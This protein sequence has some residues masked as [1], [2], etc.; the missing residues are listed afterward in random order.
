[1][2]SSFIRTNHKLPR[3]PGGVIMYV[4][5]IICTGEL[6]GEKHRTSNQNAFALHS[7]PLTPLLG[8]DMNAYDAYDAV[9]N[10][11]ICTSLQIF[12]W[13]FGQ[14]ALWVERYCTNQMP[15]SILIK[16][17]DYH[18]VEKPIL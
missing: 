14:D 18:R 10:I 12:R 9:G 17:R 2:V 16:K 3:L 8:R 15:I 1:M 6:G 4:Q 13:G 5:Y 7:T 11:W